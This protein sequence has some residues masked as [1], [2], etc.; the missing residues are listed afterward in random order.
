MSH[1]R[2]TQQSL[3]VALGASGK[4]TE[5]YGEGGNEPKDREEKIAHALKRTV[6]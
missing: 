2:Q 6:H 4:V 1:T 5:K 3:E